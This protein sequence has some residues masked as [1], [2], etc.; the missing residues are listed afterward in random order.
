[1]G[2]SGGGGGYYDDENEEQTRQP[3]PQ[4]SHHSHLQQLPVHKLSTSSTKY[5]PRSLMAIAGLGGSSGGVGGSGSSLSSRNSSPRNSIDISKSFLLSAFTGSSS[6]PNSSSTTVGPKHQQI[7]QRHSEMQVGGCSVG[8]GVVGLNAFVSAA[9]GIERQGSQRSSSGLGSTSSGT[10]TAQV[11]PRT[12]LRGVLSSSL[13][14]TT[15]D[16]YSPPPQQPPHESVSPIQGHS[17]E[18]GCLVSFSL[19]QIL[20]ILPIHS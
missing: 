13:K 4:P 17:V 20:P 16:S 5:S 10:V 8:S 14:S 7:Q 19:L 11:T 9:L 15:T 12:P 6:N 2:S 18:K 3:T 1:M